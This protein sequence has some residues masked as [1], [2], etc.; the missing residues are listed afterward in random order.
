MDDLFNIIEE[1]FEIHI[2]N[3]KVVYKKVLN[4]YYLLY[5]GNKRYFLKD[6]GTNRN[7]IDMELFKI[8]LLDGNNYGFMCLCDTCGEYIIQY[9]TH[10]FLIFPYVEQVEYTY[11]LKCGATVVEF[12]KIINSC[13][14]EVDKVRNYNELLD[15]NE[16]IVNSERELLK[17]YDKEQ[18]KK[19]ISLKDSTAEPKSVDYNKII[20]GDMTLSNVLH[21]GSKMVFIDYEDLCRGDIYSDIATMMISFLGKNC[22]HE[23]RFFL[24]EVSKAY[25]FSINYEKLKS[26]FAL[27]I[28]RS[29]RVLLNKRG[30]LLRLPICREIMRQNLLALEFLN[31]ELIRVQ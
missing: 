20:H 11:S 31:T 12:W 26:Y 15:F 7:F 10:F 19:L 8:K 21:N 23:I 18:M 6:Y 2:D 13:H 27:E 24:D 25:D 1:K 28:M 14:L 5:S 3:Y 29:V 4:I 9:K 16:C 22:E 30:V 17:Y